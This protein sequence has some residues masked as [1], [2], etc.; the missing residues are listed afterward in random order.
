MQTIK[1]NNSNLKKFK[2]DF[3]FGLAQ[4]DVL[5]EVIKKKFGNDIIKTKERSIFD[6]ESDNVLVELKSRRVK[7][8]T[9]PDTM[10]GI[11][12][13]DFAS[14]SDKEVYFAFQFTDNLYYWKYD[15]DELLNFRGGGRSDRGKNEYKPY[16]YI[17]VNLLSLF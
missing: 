13:I 4:E 11:N 15:K 14:K 7:K 1:N 10:I 17:P 12:K 2:D 5:L 6:Y 16:C 9:Y 8:D 3:I